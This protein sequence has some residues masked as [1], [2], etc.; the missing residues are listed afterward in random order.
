MSSSRAD[1]LEIIYEDDDEGAVSSDASDEYD[2]DD[3]DARTSM[4]GHPDHP[5]REP[6]RAVPNM[7]S[8]D[9]DTTHARSVIQNN[10]KVKTLKAQIKDMRTH[11]A[12]LAREV[13]RA[14]AEMARWRARCRRIEDERD[15]L[16]RELDRIIMGLST[17]NGRPQSAFYHSSFDLDSSSSIGHDNPVSYFATRKAVCSVSYEILLSTNDRAPQIILSPPLH[18]LPSRFLPRHS[19]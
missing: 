8:V 11:M 4:H 18:P 12:A 3:T 17:P 2:D 1:A 6:R 15:A 19:P 13:E 9:V 16:R 14:D 7:H 5:H 10:D